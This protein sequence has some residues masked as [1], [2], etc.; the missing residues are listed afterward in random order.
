MTRAWSVGRTAVSERSEH[1][2][3]AR[4]VAGQC[5]LERRPFTPCDRCV[6]ACRVKAITL[7]SG[8]VHI[9][10]ANCLG[11]GACEAAC[12]TGAITASGFSA[13][14][15]LRHD[16]LHISCA[17]VPAS[18]R[19]EDAW[20][21]PC[22][23]GV[24]IALLAAEAALSRDLRI[25]IDDHGWCP[26]C[27]ASA[28][29]DEAGR[30][31]ARLESALATPGQRRVRIE[32]RPLD[33][34]HALPPGSGPKRSRRA[35]FQA[36]LAGPTPTRRS[37]ALADRAALAALDPAALV[38]PILA[39]GDACADHG[40][41]SA[42]CPTG[43]LRRTSDDEGR[44]TLRFEPD[45]CIEC[46][47]CAEVCPE[48]ALQLRL[49]VTAAVEPVVLREVMMAVCVRCESQFVAGDD[50]DIECPGCRKDAGLFH[51]LRRSL[52]R[53]A[54][55]PASPAASS[56]AVASPSGGPT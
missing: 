23:R 41:C 16:A 50:G 26:N 53:P 39:I 21:V 8:T 25:V 47:R 52:S 33:A 49:S 36:L 10:K 11:C 12:P 2:P 18:L 13:P 55:S 27:P 43:A 22:F 32:S 44:L 51:D 15:R 9:D 4:R 30:L 7:I 20:V 35:V 46:G 38:H 17:R 42:A 29:T 34:R 14:P 37:G 19:T 28:G 24:T 1:A 3:A 56:G 54:F 5:L 31:H 6:D 40:V 48:H 45:K